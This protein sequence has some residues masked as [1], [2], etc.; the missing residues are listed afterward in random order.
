M[1][2]VN[3]VGPS[4]RLI[5]TGAEVSFQFEYQSDLPNVH[6][7]FTI[8][9]DRGDSL[10]SLSSSPSAAVDV[11]DV[12]DGKRFECRLDECPLMP[13]RYRLNVAL[14]CGDEKL[15]HVEGAISFNVE[16]GYM[17]GRPVRGDG[18]YGRIVTPHV[19]KRMTA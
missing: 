10:L 7:A 2:S 13:G 16:G 18:A 4:D 5:S 11:I 17:R 14:H 6:C 12:P 19:W 8:Y 1:L 15:D 9:D 3:A